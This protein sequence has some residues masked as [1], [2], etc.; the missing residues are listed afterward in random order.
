MTL[1]HSLM[2]E[3]QI[4][5]LPPY[6]PQLTLRYPSTVPLS[7][8]PPLHFIPPS[9]PSSISLHAL[10]VPP[11]QWLCGFLHLCYI[12]EFRGRG[13]FNQYFKQ[14]G[15]R[16]L[17]PNATWQHERMTFEEGRERQPRNTYCYHQCS[18]L[19]GWRWLGGRK[20]KRTLMREI[21]DHWREEEIS[22]K[23]RTTG[24]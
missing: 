11:S 10:F 5:W 3:S 20:R 22:G 23:V 8:S 6:D 12:M 19:G 13:H 14:H 21:R 2:D 4:Q 18:D 9:R 15:P 16:G 1:V 24:R 7:H 17:V